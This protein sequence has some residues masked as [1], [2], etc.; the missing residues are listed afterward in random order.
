VA[1]NSTAS[2]ALS[3]VKLLN[4]SEGGLAVS[5]GALVI[6]KGLFEDMIVLSR[7][8]PSLRRNILCKDAGN[9]RLESLVNVER[10]AQNTSLWIRNVDC[11]LGGLPLFYASELF[12]PSLV[13]DSCA[14]GRSGYT[15]GMKGNRTLQFTVRML[16]PRV[17]LRNVDV[18]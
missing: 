4:A 15:G 5:G 9:L 1:L 12:V 17:S 18:G 2:A 3:H 7:E 14:R 8:Y 6:Q 11:T 13:C 16:L 10:S